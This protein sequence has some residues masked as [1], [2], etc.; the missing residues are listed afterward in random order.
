[1]E[2]VTTAEC[3]SCGECVTV[4]PVENTLV[5]SPFRS[6]FSLSPLAVTLIVLVL[7]GGIVTATTLTGDFIWNRNANLPPTLQRILKGPERI[8]GDNSLLEIVYA[9]RIP[10]QLFAEQ[11]EGLTEEHF[12][13]TLDEAGL[14][15]ES[16]RDLVV[17]Y[18][19]LYGTGESHGGESSPE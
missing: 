11:F 16:V 17:M 1:M 10:P 8:A 6:R 3:I 7:F 19:S 2:E 18:Q 5:E 12:Y 9:Y 4:C 13:V 15:V 14:D